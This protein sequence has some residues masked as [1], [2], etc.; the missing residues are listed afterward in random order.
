V[1]ATLAIAALFN[2][3]RR[4]LQTTIDRR[5][6]RGKY[7]AARTLAAF[8]ATLRS[9][10]NFASLR[11]HLLEVVD[12]TMRPDHVSLWLPAKERPGE[13]PR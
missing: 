10:V 9:E 13:A 4:R 5:F 6:Y 2:P 7:D 8:A 11:E 12:D 3:L 1:V